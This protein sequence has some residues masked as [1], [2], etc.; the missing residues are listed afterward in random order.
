MAKGKCPK[1][2]SSDVNVTNYLGVK[3]VICDNCHYD[4]AKDYEVYGENKPSQKAK[5]SYSP[6]KAGGHGRARK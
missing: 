3:C 4:Q 5:G 1:C 6:Y 2:G